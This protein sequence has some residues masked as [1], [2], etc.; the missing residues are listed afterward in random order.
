MRIGIIGGGVVGN[1]TARAWLEHCEDVMVYDADPKR[2]THDFVDVVRCDVVCV[3][4]PTPMREDGTGIDTRIV[5]SVLHDV[6]VI[7]SSSIVAVRST[8]PVGYCALVAKKY[9]IPNLIHWPEFLTARCA[10]TD[11]MMPTRNVIGTVDGV[12]EYAYVPFSRQVRVRWPSVPFYQGS[13]EESEFVKLATNAFFATKVAFWNEAHRY[14]KQLFQN[15]TYWGWLMKV[16]LSD[17]R[18][19]PSHTQVPGPDGQTGFG[20]ACL[21]KDLREFINGMDSIGVQNGVARA[22]YDRNLLIDRG[23]K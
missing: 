21:P 2:R 7:R 16:I 22:A 6:A 8:V 15:E 5:D 4:V 10:V 12:D 19:H 17:G 11:A 1:A 9:K 23:A 14:A 20:G 13:S 18:I 3:C